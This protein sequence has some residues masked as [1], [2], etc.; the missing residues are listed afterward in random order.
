MPKVL[1]IPHLADLSGAQQVLLD[2]AA[3]IDPAK[4]EIEVIC[5]AEGPFCQVL[6]GK[7]A[8]RIIPNPTVSIAEEKTKSGRLRLALARLRYILTLRKYIASA[9]PDI[10][11]INTIINIYAGIAAKFA[12]A[13]V[14]YYV[15]EIF[16]LTRRNRFKYWIVEKTA[17]WILGPSPANAAMFS[18]KA[19]IKFTVLPYG[20]DT[21]PFEYSAEQRREV[22]VKYGIPPEQI[23]IGTMCFITPRKGVDDFLKAALIAHRQAPESVFLIVGSPD[24]SSQDYFAK[25]EAYA[26]DNEMGGYVRFLPHTNNVSE[27]F[28]LF[29]MFALASLSESTPRVI[30]EAMASSIPV[31]ATAVGGVASM[32][33]D[34]MSGRLVGP[35]QPVQLAQAMLEL[36]HDEARRKEMGR[37]GLQKVK[38]YSRGAFEQAIHAALDTVVKAP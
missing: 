36:L 1:L 11:F 19:Q 23:V 26:R 6:N 3:A 37:R 12:G 9:R 2:V 25:L 15:H 27:M 24:A 20:I 8:W 29:D 32:V 14:I 31:I 35:R 38:Q 18:R 7:I 5:P 34:G 33:E 16:P 28:A 10:V 22:R 21:E 17:N 4:Y 30:L 13:R